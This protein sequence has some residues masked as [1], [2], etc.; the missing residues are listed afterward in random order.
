MSEVREALELARKKLINAAKVAGND[1]DVAHASVEF[2]DRAIA[3][4]ADGEGW[5][6]IET[7]PK[8]GESI[9][10]ACGGKYP[11]VDQAE[12]STEWDDDGM[13]HATGGKRKSGNSLGYVPTHWSPLPSPP[14]IRTG[15]N[16]GPR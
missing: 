3:F 7:A 8:D 9:L 6:P 1:D 5:R 13:W 11:S 4:L 14:S 16:D 2:I 12:W 15:G 10:V